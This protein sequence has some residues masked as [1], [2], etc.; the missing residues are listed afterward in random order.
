MKTHL[1]LTIS[2]SP[3]DDRSA[4]KRPRLTLHPRGG[5]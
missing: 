2:D 5:I 4:S 3:K 1:A